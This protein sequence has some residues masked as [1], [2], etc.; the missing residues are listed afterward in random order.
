MRIVADQIGRE[1]QNTYVKINNFFLKN[2]AIILDNVKK[3]GTDGQAKDDNKAH[4]H[5]ML[6]T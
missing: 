1:N 3:Y 4:E 5:C 6:Y 2:C